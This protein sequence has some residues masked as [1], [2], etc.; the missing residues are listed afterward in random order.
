MKKASLADVRAEF[1]AFLDESQKKQTNE[2]RVVRIARHEEEM[3]IAKRGLRNTEA[4][5]QES[6]ICDL[7][8]AICDSGL[9]AVSQQPRAPQHGS[10]V[11]LSRLM[12]R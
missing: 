10:V 12:F 1:G 11:P 2:N 7:L 6:V 4:R 8:F 9:L 5:S 3:R